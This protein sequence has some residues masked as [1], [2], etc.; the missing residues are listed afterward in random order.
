VKL[1]GL[2]YIVGFYDGFDYAHNDLDQIF[3]NVQQ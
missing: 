1:P 2:G 3:P